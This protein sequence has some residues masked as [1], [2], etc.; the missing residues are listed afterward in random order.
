MRKL[1][2]TIIAMLV[3]CCVLVSC[4]SST[5]SSNN[6]TDNSSS[7]KT[8]ANNSDEEEYGDDDEYS[9]DDDEY[10]DDDD[11]D[12]D[13]EDWDAYITKLTEE[14]L[15]LEQ[16]VEDESDEEMYDLMQQYTG[17]SYN[18][19]WNIGSAKKLEGKTYVLELWLTERGTLW[20]RNEMGR[21]QGEIDIALDWL[22]R[23]AAQFGKSASF[24]VGA[25]YGD[26]DGVVMNRIPHS[27][28]DVAKHPNLILE[29]LQ[30]IGYTGVEQCY[31]QLKNMQ[32]VDNVVLILLLNHT[33]RSCANIFTRGHI[34]YYDTQFLEGVSIFNGS[35]ENPNSRLTANVVIHELLHAFGAWDMYGDAQS[36]VSQEAD[37]FTQ[38]Y[39]PYEIMGRGAHAPINQIMI[40]PLTAWL[41]GLSTEYH[42]EWYWSFMRNL[43]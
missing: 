13:D 28:E 15:L 5:S 21:I 1:L 33:G 12:W 26:G 11:E 25:F 27:Y 35:A 29:A 23:A 4:G 2:F 20:N 41:T 43:N 8:S 40:S 32:G 31:D 34:G 19:T 42:P 14:S 37:Q 16:P 9:D 39:Y 30:V 17:D 18:N 3:A 36:G 38:T 10:S 7:N 24:E 22:K 6:A